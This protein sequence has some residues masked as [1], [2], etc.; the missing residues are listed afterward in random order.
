MISIDQI[1]TA[2]QIESVRILVREFTDFALTLNPEALNAPS[3]AG[4]EEQLADLPGIFGPP[5]GAF[6]L[7]T[8]DGTPAGCIAYFSHGNDVC[9]VKRMYVRPEFRGIQLGEKLTQSLIETARARGYQKIILNTFHKL[10]A[11]QN[12]YAKAGFTLCTPT[13]ELPASDEGKAVFM[14]L[15]L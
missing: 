2:E 6:L 15:N 10:E 3:F 1:E 8:V 11:A 7:A 4:L 5:D 13:V 9:E 14:E 12:L